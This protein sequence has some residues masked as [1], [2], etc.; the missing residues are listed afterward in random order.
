MTA[1]RKR[2]PSIASEIAAIIKGGLFPRVV[3]KPDGST[4]VTGV[5]ADKLDIPDE[6]GLALGRRFDAELGSDAGGDGD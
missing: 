4:E 5:P 6:E 1:V 2:K 3:H